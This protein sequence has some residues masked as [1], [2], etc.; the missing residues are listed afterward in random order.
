[1]S[2]AHPMNLSRA[3]W[4]RKAVEAFGSSTGADLY[5]E[6]IGDLLCDLGHLC[7][8]EGLDFVTLVRGAVAN[9]KIEQTD[10]DGLQN[11]PRVEI[12]IHG[13]KDLP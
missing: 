13:K 9:W 12:I 11:P 10:P 8:Q 4:A 2:A 7:D 1:M 3:D 5:E 6:A